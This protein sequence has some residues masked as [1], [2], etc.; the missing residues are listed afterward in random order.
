[1]RARFAAVF[2]AISLETTAA[3]W[4]IPAVWALGSWLGVQV[5]LFALLLGTALTA[6]LRRRSAALSALGIGVGILL[7]GSFAPG[8][9]NLAA[10]A[11]SILPSARILVLPL[12]VQPW[13]LRAEFRRGLILWLIVGILRSILGHPA[14]GPLVVMALLFLAAALIG[15]P[16]LHSAEALGQ[17][18]GAF[19]RAMPGLRVSL[20]VGLVG[21]GLAVLIAAVGALLTPSRLS[22]LGQIVAEALYAVVYLP[23]RLLGPIVDAVRR[24]LRPFKP[25]LN[26]TP[27]VGPH[28]LQQNLQ[29]LARNTHILFIAGGIVL[30]LAILL[31]AFF[32]ARLRR[33]SED[34]KNRPLSPGDALYESLTGQRRGRPDFGLGARRV[35]R[36]AVWRHL[37]RQF[38]RDIPASTTARRLAAEESWPDDVLRG[39]EEA[40]YRLREDLDRTLLQRFLEAFRAIRDRRRRGQ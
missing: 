7:C 16:V 21:L 25:R 9:F 29:E 39:Y 5:P 23:L 2:P 30:L 10:A 31:A 33:E 6:V 36:T 22:A 3:F 11:F 13:A 24:R 1:M 17:D 4:V 26:K 37:R 38:G 8:A 28:P 40:R 35:V 18:Q 27:Q 12:R 15:L 20:L 34:M 14:L 19:Q 32:V